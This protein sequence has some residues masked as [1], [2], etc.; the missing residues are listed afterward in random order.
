VDPDLREML[1]VLQ[2]GANDVICISAVPPFA[3][4]HAKT[5]SRQLRGS[6]PQTKLVVGGLVSEAVVR[7]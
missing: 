5:L 2:P 1:E 6:F 3:F 4:S 7:P